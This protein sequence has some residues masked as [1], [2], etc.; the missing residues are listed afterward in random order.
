MSFGDGNNDLEMLTL[1]GKSYAMK[2]GSNETHQTAQQLAPTNDED[3]VLAVIESL[4]E[5]Q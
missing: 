5:I 3:G 2:N 4:L 1:A